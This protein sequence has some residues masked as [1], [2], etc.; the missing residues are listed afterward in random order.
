MKK[1]YLSV[2]LLASLLLGACKSDSDSDNDTPVID[3]KADYTE[4]T[5]SEAPKW[6]IDWSN[7][8][9]RPNW[10]EPDASSYENWTILMVQI[11]ETLQPFVSKDDLMAIFVNGELRGL[12]K[13]AIA[14]G[15]E[16]AVSNQFVM[17]AYGNETG[18][19]TVNMSLKYYCQQLKHLFTLTDDI[20]LDSDESTGTDEDYIPPFT[21]G[22]A[23]Y[24]VVM[25]LDAT[26]ILAKANIAP[27]AGDMLAAFV[28][29]ECR[30]VGQAAPG[31]LTLTVYGRQN[32]ENITL[33]YYQAATGKVFTFP[34][35]AKTKQL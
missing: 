33:M 7:D 16:Q 29:D 27:V 3:N 30:G 9:D 4:T 12:A 17:K 28:G 14:V 25:T 1:I 18:T 8:Q 19:E 20:T 31:Q 13:P 22:S 24:P 10:S 6:Q 26:S 11:E 23:K 35:A 5:V 21:L 15:N 2:A 34:N 32:D